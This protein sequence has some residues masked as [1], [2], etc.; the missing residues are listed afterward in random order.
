MENP[1]QTFYA[2]EELFALK[3]E[4]IKMTEVKPATPSVVVGRE[5]PAVVVQPNTRKPS[6][7]VKHKVIIIGGIILLGCIGLYFYSENKKAKKGDEEN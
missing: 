3:P 6:V 2:P 1:K 5:I 7:W 4:P